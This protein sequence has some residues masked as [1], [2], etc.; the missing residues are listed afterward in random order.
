MFEITWVVNA[1]GEI[2]SASFEMASERLH[3]RHMLL[4]MPHE[5]TVLS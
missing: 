3:M 2:R 5:Y 4:R 1:T